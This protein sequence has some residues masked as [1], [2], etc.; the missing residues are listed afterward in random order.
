[1][2][3]KTKLLILSLVAPLLACADYPR[4]LSAPA[5]AGR[6]VSE[7]GEPVAGAVVVAR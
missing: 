3:L 5:L 7:T 1:M 6:V 4:E 2:R